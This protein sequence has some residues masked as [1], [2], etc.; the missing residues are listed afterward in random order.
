MIST[1]LWLDAADA[2][3]VTTVSGAVSQWNDKSGNARNVSQSTAGN[4]PTYT[5]TG[6]NGKAVLTFDGSNDSLLNSSVGLPLGASA[7]SLYVVYQPNR[8]TGV[9]AIC[10]QGTSLASG[11]L[12][13]I[14][15]RSQGDPYFAGF[16]RDVSNGTSFPFDNTNP[17][18]AEAIFNGSALSLY[19]T[20][21]LVASQTL[22]LNT[23]GDSFYVGNNPNNEPMGGTV[24][25]IV[26]TASASSTLDRQ[27]IEG[28][29]AH[30]WGLTAN[31]PADHP[32]KTVGPTP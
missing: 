18:I 25:E 21:N 8:L 27:R 17:K 10:G 29:L 26:V 12:Y 19:S 9:N 5:A 23:I 31:L 4:R 7:R 3:T 13:Y 20:G 11:N 32:Y 14:Q 6:L 30:K 28:Y 2:T 16:L 15:F 24:A 1:A 22:S